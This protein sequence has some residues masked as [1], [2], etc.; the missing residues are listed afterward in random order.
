MG[1]KHVVERAVSQSQTRSMPCMVG[2]GAV[3]RVMK[4]PAGNINKRQQWGGR[5]VQ[6]QRCLTNG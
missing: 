6:A 4:G 2:I 1:I 5:K 3:S